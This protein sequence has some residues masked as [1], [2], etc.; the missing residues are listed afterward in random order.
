MRW[1]MTL[2]YRGAPFHGW[3]RQPGDVSVQSTIE[4]ALAT[5]VREPVPVTGAGRTDAGVNARMMVAHLDLPDCIDPREARFVRALNSLVG[6]DIAI[7]SFRAVASDSH[8]RFDASERSYRYFV[9]TSKSP[10]TG[11]LSW[12]APNGLDFEAMNAAAAMLTGRRDFT[13]FAKLHSDVKT[14]ICD[15]RC[16]VWHRIDSSNWYFEIAADRFLRNMVRAVVGT[17]VE[18][19]RGKR[20]PEWVADVLECRDRCA[21]GTSMPA[22]AL[23]LWSVEYPEDIYL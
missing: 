4:D 12:Y 1:F 16:A 15:L 11:G 7:Q 6:R 21:A 20:S 8:A 18:I 10:F 3:Q 14:N 9:H 23:F 2:S 17:L 5:L 22:E 19:G 13:S